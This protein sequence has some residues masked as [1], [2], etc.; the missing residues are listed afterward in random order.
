[1]L[2]HMIIEHI[3]LPASVNQMR[4]I[5]KIYDIYAGELT[6]NNPNMMPFIINTGTFSWFIFNR[7]IA[8]PVF[9]LRR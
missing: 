8:S 1:M 3:I 6:K 4:T 5:K 7:L 2:S 9:T